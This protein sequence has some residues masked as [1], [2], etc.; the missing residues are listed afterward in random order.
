MM[1]KFLHLLLMIFV[2]A[3]ASAMAEGVVINEVMS[4][5]TLYIPVEGEYAGWVE[6]CNL[7]DEA[8][9]ISGWY[10]TDSE[11]FKNAFR[12]KDTVLQ[13]GGTAIV[14]AAGVKETV[15]D[16]VNVAEFKI[17]AAG[18]MLM[19]TD[20]RGDAVDRTNV[21]A[22]GV[23]EAWV[24]DPETGEWA[25]AF[26]ATPGMANTRENYAHLAQQL[27]QTESDVVISEAMA[28]N[29]SFM[30]ENGCPDWIELCNLGAS[31]VDLTG[32][33]IADDPENPQNGYVLPSVTL[34]S[35][36]YMIIYADGRG[37]QDET[38]A[39]HANFSLSRKGETLVLIDSMGRLASRM[40]FGAV[41]ADVSCSRQ[42]DGAFTT[43]LTASPGWPNTE[44]GA[45]QAVM[46]TSASEWMNFNDLGLYINEI[47]TATDIV[48]LDKLSYD[49]VEIVNLSENTIDLTDFGL[50][51]REDRPRKWQFPQGAVIAPGEFLLV[52]L[53]GEDDAQSNVEKKQYR[54][55]FSLGA[56]G[57]ETLVLATA[58]GTVIDRVGLGVQRQNVSFGRPLTG[59]RYA[60]FTLSTPG[61]ANDG[62]G[63]DTIAAKVLFSVPGGVVQGDSITVSLSAEQGM[64]IYYT[65]DCSEPTPNSM[66]YTGP[67]TLTGNTVV[68]AV[69]YRDGAVYS[70]IA[71]Q[72]YIF[73]EDTNLR[74][75]SVVAEPDELYGSN[76]IIANSSKRR[77]VNANVEVYTQYG[78]QLLDQGCRMQL[79]GAGSLK[80]SQKSMRLMADAAY[81][82]NLFRAKLFDKREY[83]EYD[84]FVLRSSGQDS[85]KTRMH[86]SILTSLLEG[87]CVMY[88][89][90]ET[91]VVYVNGQYYGHMNMRERI[92]PES[93]C[94]F[95]GWDD[96][97]NVDILEN[98]GVLVAG[99][100]D[101]WWDLVDWVKDVDMTQE[102]N[103]QLLA[104]R[105]DIENY[106]TYV[107][108][109]QFIANNDLGNVRWYRNANQDGKWRF[110]A[111]DT[112]LSFQTDQNSL[113]RWLKKGGVG[114]ITRQDNTMF[115]AMM[116][117]DGLRDQFLTILG[118]MMAGP[119]ST[120]A[121]QAKVDARYE[122]IH[123]D[124][125]QTFV[126]FGEGDEAKWNKA[127]K[128][129]YNYAA[130]RPAKYLGYIQE[131]LNFTEDE[132]RVYFGRV[133]DQIAGVES[134]DA[135]V[136]ESEDALIQ[137]NPR[138]EDDAT[139]ADD[140]MDEAPEEQQF[141]DLIP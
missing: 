63:Y 113:E 134:V 40:V 135:E 21:P 138:G 128:R 84:A 12:F 89:E 91:C 110:I 37:Y 115:R 52:A 99:S 8:V 28:S 81:G 87:S 78:D 126:Y 141:V 47:M 118:E 77:A 72:T 114:S 105:L 116:K 53:T 106:L 76:G 64:N 61:A 109:E 127:V 103:V 10:L 86:D 55:N 66:M 83:T 4:R 18:D 35:G 139:E 123:D 73:G 36:E 29:K 132:M 67:I 129:F 38:G 27:L 88:Q 102:S 11:I 33:T 20:S 107:A 60:Y 111:Y 17:S 119:W 6:V 25:A 14:Y 117:N 75:V 69:A 90:T 71:T 19:L 41:E 59:D 100:G 93:I 45:R 62:T 16:P 13:P 42:N 130:V 94:Q 112:D 82:D 70:Q 58:D 2:L 50:S 74:V 80:Q 140:A 34:N 46:S 104:E 120:A 30:M 121:I 96:P 49:W 32:W 95:H 125:V 31:P 101:D 54:A 122:E 51:D 7:S 108:F 5:N 24:R 65:L 92:N 98:K 9:D 57:G 43:E 131:T 68:R 85:W 3:G 1:R 44:N 26:D 136:F 22:L 133:M 48:N 79:M 97:E 15:Y 23:D 124:A 39:L 137:E 56:S